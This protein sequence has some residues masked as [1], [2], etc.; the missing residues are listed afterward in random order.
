VLP[1]ERLATAFGMRLGLLDVQ[2]RLALPVPQQRIDRLLAQAADHHRDYGFLSWRDRCPDELVD[3]Y[4]ALK[5][6]MNTQAP[7]G[8]LKVEDEHW[9]EGRLRE[10]EQEM[11]DSGRT[12]HVWVAV[13]PDGALAGHNELVVPAH[14]PDVVFQ[15]DTLVRVEHRG[16]RLGLALK[17][18]NLD[19]V[20]TTHPGRTDVRTFN[21]LT[22]THMIAVNE[23][24]GFVPVEYMGEW[25]GPV[26]A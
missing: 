20:Q 19:D 17:V 13:A 14:D 6:S 18:R 15:W 12:R 11:L 10:E 3:A 16:H 9:D 5:A 4:C 22:N 26:P 21:A 1:G 7:T 23:A 2:R 24:I 25:Q 8:D